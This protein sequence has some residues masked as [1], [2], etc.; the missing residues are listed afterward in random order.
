MYADINISAKSYAVEMFKTC[1]KTG[2]PLP[3]AKF[4]LFNAQGGLITSGITDVNGKLGFRT[5]IVE[6]II[7]QEH[8]LYYLQEI[9][10]PT[11]Y[12]LDDTKYW[13]CF[14][15]DTGDTCIDCNKLMIDVAAVRI[16]FEQIGMINIANYPASIELP[17]TGSVGIQIYILCGLTL[18]VCPL[19]Y[20][21]GLR[22]RHRRR[23]NK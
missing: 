21:F 3:G 14:C 9:Q 16:P 22:H 7:L 17:A 4:G 11:A 10:P 2:K 23:F 8:N 20:G 13:F 1:A 6:G 12:E 18:V 19:V 5:N 15:N